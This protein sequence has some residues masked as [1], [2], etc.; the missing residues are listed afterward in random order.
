[1]N[2]EDE[3]LSNMSE[4]VPTTVPKTSVAELLQQ[5]VVEQTPTCMPIVPETFSV[6]EPEPPMVEQTPASTRKELY[7]V[8]T[9]SIFGHHFCR[10]SRIMLTGL[11]LVKS[12]NWFSSATF[13]QIKPIVML[14]SCQACKMEQ[15]GQN[16]IPHFGVSLMI[17]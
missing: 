11:V 6:E 13:D 12:P 14:L 8:S 4:N 9:F 15:H 7:A 17:G 2:D 10:V 16:T 5:P 3:P 1:M